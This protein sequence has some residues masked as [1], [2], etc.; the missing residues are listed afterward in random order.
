MC[1]FFF[2][3]LTIIVAC[4][5][6]TSIVGKWEGINITQDIEFLRDGSLIIHEKPKGRPEMTYVGKYNFIEKNRLKIEVSLPLM[7]NMVLI[8]EVS[9]SGNELIL[10][11]G[12]NRHNRIEK[13]R[14]V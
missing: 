10:K 11:G 7:G 5:Q 14:K 3:S 4:G 1:Y 12:Y 13:Y 6:D 2:A 8:F 9:F